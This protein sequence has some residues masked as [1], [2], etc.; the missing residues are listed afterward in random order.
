MVET[1]HNDDNAYA[2]AT[3]DQGHDQQYVADASKF[4]ENTSLDDMLDMAEKAVRRKM[5]ERAAEAPKWVFPEDGI[6]KS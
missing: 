5:M 4:I 1:S 3:G 6:Q 2:G